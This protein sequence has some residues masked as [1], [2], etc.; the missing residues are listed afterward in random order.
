MPKSIVTVLAV[1]VLAL[2]SGCDTLHPLQAVPHI[3]VIT[4]PSQQLYC[5]SPMIWKV[6][7]SS[8]ERQ[9]V[10]EEFGYSPPPLVDYKTVAEELK[11]L[12]NFREVSKVSQ[13]FCR[14]PG[15]WE[16]RNDPKGQEGTSKVAVVCRLPDRSMVGWYWGWGG[17]WAYPGYGMYRY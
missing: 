14:C 12:P 6:R 10:C 15:A 11:Q 4:S 3:E 13:V 8:G 17:W 1:Y 2:L 7:E 9:A 5:K 16:I